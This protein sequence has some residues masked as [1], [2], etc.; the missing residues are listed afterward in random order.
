MLYIS[1]FPGVIR[2]DSTVLGGLVSAI[3]KVQWTA[4]HLGPIFSS[5]D[6]RDSIEQHS[7]MFSHAIPTRPEKI[8]KR[9]DIR[10]FLMAVNKK[11][12]NREADTVEI[13]EH[14]GKT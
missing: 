8:T 2:L 4:R 1:S 10:S 3:F 5:S 12:G 7:Q 14:Y 11:Q 6:S 9:I 13:S